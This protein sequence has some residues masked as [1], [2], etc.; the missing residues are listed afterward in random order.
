MCNQIKVHLQD[1]NFSKYLIF[2]VKATFHLIGK[3]ISSETFVFG[4]LRLRMLLSV[5]HE[6]FF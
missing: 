3:E 4:H 2:S 1:D 5:A 6:G